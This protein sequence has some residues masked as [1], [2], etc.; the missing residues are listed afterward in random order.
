MLITTAL[1]GALAFLISY[2][3]VPLTVPLCRITG[4][5]DTPDGVRKL[6][7]T[8]IPR[9]GGIAIYLAALATLSPF[10]SEDR[11]VGAILAGGAILVAGGV[12]DD[13]YDIPP[14]AKLIIQ[15]S[16][17]AVAI[18]VAGVPGSLSLFGILNLPLAGPIGFVIVLLRMI[19]TTNAVNFSDGLDGLAAGISASALFA[20]AVWGLYNGNAYPATA[21]L[22][23]G[24]A[25]LGFLPYNKYRARVYMGDCGAQFLGLCIALISVGASRDGSY[26]LESSLF[27]AVPA[28]DTFVAVARRILS[29]KNPLKADRGHLHHLLLDRGVSHP[30]ASR[31]LSALSALIAAATLLMIFTA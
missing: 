29:G 12:C 25:V 17:S 10:I 30:D 20:M 1:L 6:N 5:F 3:T 16:A 19:F 18:A 23:I 14:V 9:L 24:F 31:L 26:T 2:V 8:P 27:L 7:T 21:A 13:T 28:L 22:V 15:L 4:A 11:T